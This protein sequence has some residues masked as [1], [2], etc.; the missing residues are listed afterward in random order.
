MQDMAWNIAI[1]GQSFNSKH[2]FFVFLSHT[3]Q[4]TR[5]WPV[6]P[7]WESRKQ[8]SLLSSRRWTHDD[9]TIIII[10]VQRDMPQSSL[11]ST[12]N[13]LTC[14]ERRSMYRKKWRSQSQKRYFKSCL[15][16]EVIPDTSTWTCLE[17]IPKCR[18]TYGSH[19][20][21]RWDYN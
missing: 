6:P 8:L 18:T 15:E 5:S 20:S 21:C 12:S 11:T 16:F 4:G 17:K 10:I 19:L 2:D 14:I 3:S 9:I 13:R 7:L 1:F